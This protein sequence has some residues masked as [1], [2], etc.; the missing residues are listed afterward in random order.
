VEEEDH[1]NLHK[2]GTTNKRDVNHDDDDDDS[3]SVANDDD[4]D[5]SSDDEDDDEADPLQERH[6][7]RQ[8]SHAIGEAV[9]MEENLVINKEHAKGTSSPSDPAMVAKDKINNMEGSPQSSS[10]SA[11]DSDSDSSSTSSSEEESDEDNGAD[12][13][14]TTSIPTHKE[15]SFPASAP[16]APPTAH[17]KA[18]DDDD[19]FLV[20][21]DSVAVEDIFAHAKEQVPAFDAARNDKSQG[22]A[23]QRQRPGSQFNKRRRVRR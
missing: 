7:L 17:D 14:T 16:H 18:N 15:P 21:N 19:D 6:T 2:P 9:R 22:W 23:T 10:D 1:Q 12:M 4:D 5:D 11:S 8:Q 3:A 13:D 20:S